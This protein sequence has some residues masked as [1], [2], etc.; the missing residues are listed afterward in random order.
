[1]QKILLNVCSTSV[2]GPLTAP[3]VMMRIQ[4]FAQQV[5]TMFFTMMMVIIII[6]IIIDH[7]DNGDQCE[8]TQFDD[9]E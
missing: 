3:M 1:M 6:I 2:M 7:D 9:K 4:G 8:S 5:H